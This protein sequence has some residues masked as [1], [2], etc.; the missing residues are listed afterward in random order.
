MASVI[1]SLNPELKFIPQTIAGDLVYVVKE[2]L[3]AE[4]FRFSEDEYDL[5]KLFDGRHSPRQV[6]QK[7]NSLHTSIEV[8]AQDVMAFERSLKTMGLLEVTDKEM[9]DRLIELRKLQKNNALM[10][11]KGSIT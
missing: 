7:F 11:S 2:P 6:A 4:I 5:M 8:T 3:K 9:K 1:R 10:N